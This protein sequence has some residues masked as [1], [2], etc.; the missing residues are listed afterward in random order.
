MTFFY[1]VR[2]K[3]KENLK[4]TV[5]LNHLQ[6]IL[7]LDPE[8]YKIEWSMSPGTRNHELL[9]TLPRFDSQEER[10]NQARKKILCYLLAME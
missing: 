5:T 2:K 3:I 1:I 9:V 6:Q 4:I 8:H 10:I 7:F